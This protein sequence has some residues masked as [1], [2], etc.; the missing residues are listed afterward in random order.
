MDI[1]ELLKAGENVESIRAAF[2]K[3]LA[4]ANEKLRKER[5]REAERIV[6]DLAIAREELIDSIVTYSETYL[7]ALIGQPCHFSEKEIKTIEQEL[8]DQEKELKTYFKDA[9]HLTPDETRD[10]LTKFI[11][12]YVLTDSSI[13]GTEFPF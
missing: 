2:G 10:E 1:Y 11:K 9:P 12:E 6:H 13:P 4:E 3:E 7:E 5:E 8:L